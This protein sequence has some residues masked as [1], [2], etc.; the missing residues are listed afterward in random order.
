MIFTSLF[1]YKAVCAALV[2]VLLSLIVEYMSPKWAGIFSGFPT[3]TAIILYFYGLQYGIEFAGRSAIYN[4]IGLIA[5]QMFL[6]GYYLSSVLKTRCEILAS[7]AGG[8]FAYLT[9]IFILSIFSFN[10]FW[11]I[12]IPISSF[13]IFHFLFRKIPDIRVEKRRKTTWDVIALRATFAALTIS[14]ITEIAEFIGPNWAGLLST[15]PSTLFPLMLIIH[16]SYGQQFVHAMIKHV[17]SGLG[18]LLAYSVVLYLSYPSAG[19]YL[20]MLLALA[21]ALLYLIVF[22]VII[23]ARDKLIAAS[24]N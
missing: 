2:V 5:M 17:P 4:M 24:D 7:V 15:F 9:T 8:L 6:F 11:A 12:M 14:F 18:G 16:W 3:G 22:Q 19:L 20:G 21:T 1:F 23:Y 13:F 10:V